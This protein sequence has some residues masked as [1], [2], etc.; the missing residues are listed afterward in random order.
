VA[1][2]SLYAACKHA[3][4]VAVSSFAGKAGIGAAWAR[5]FHVFGP[6][7]QPA[8]IVP[9]VIERLSRR[10]P[11]PCSDGR[12][13]R[14]YLFV[15]EVG[16]ALAMLLESGVEGA[17]NIGSGRGVTIRELVERLA[18]LVGG[19]DLLEFGAITRRESEPEVV[20]A[21]VD[22]LQNEVGF[23]PSIGLDA[24]LARTVEWFAGRPGRP[25]AVAAADIKA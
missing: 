25:R 5:I 10:E 14:D 4:N 15:D 23:V 9:A 22:R 24:G 13:S 3:L 20:V 1:P 12:Q 8:R 18:G 17:V 7:E 11:M 16:R 2:S 19:R 6:G 21:S